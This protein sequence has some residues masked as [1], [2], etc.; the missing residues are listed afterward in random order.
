MYLNIDFFV[1][2][3][4]DFWLSWHLKQN[5]FSCFS[6]RWELGKIKIKELSLIVLGAR[7]IHLKGLFYCIWLITLSLRLI[8]VIYLAWPL[9]NQLFQCL[10]NSI[11][12]H[13]GG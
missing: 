1:F 4:V 8:S 11:L 5:T 3:Y 2:E 7:S 9:I 10:L 13:L 6:D 12:M